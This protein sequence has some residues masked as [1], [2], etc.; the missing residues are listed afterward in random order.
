MMKEQ[1]VV[2]LKSGSP[3]LTVVGV[4]GDKVFVTW[5]NEKGAIQGREFPEVC[6][7]PDNGTGNREVL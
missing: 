1:D 7:V 6:L 4:T 3:P 5:L 2:R